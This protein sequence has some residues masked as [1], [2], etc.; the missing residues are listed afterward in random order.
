MAIT[1]GTIYRSLIN[2]E[3]IKYERSVS[4][5]PE[6]I[7]IKMYTNSSVYQQWLN[8]KGELINFKLTNTNIDCDMVIRNVILC[9]QI[10]EVVE[11][12]VKLWNPERVSKVF[13]K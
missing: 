8:R 3:P 12:L 6:E 11:V 9:V 5:E 13:F 7:V 10:E 2:D 1:N 4:F